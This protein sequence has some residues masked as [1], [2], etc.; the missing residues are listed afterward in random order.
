MKTDL[1]DIVTVSQPPVNLHT[2]FFKMTRSTGLKA[3]YCTII[4]CAQVFHI[5]VGGVGQGAGF[6]QEMGEKRAGSRISKTAGGGK[7]NQK[8]KLS[9]FVTA[10]HPVKETNQTTFLDSHLAFSEA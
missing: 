6:V 9:L 8:G 4:D 1:G 10:Y 7:E 5:L 3:K 2:K